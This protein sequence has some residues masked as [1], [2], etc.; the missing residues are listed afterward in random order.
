[1]R[2]RPSISCGHA[3]SRRQPPL[4][5]APELIIGIAEHFVPP[6]DEGA[7]LILQARDAP[8]IH[9]GVRG[10]TMKFPGSTLGRS[11]L[12]APSTSRLKRKI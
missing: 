11:G 1:M 8:A 10:R 4:Q 12:P 7:L 5:F 2:H 3:P 6:G 9:F